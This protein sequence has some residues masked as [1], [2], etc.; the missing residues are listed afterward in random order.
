M[1]ERTL[2]I[3]YPAL[4]VASVT[5]SSHSFLP[6]LACS[7]IVFREREREREIA[8]W[9]S[10]EIEKE[11]SLLLERLSNICDPTANVLWK[12]SPYSYCIV[13]ILAGVDEEGSAFSRACK[14]AKWKRGWDWANTAASWKQTHEADHSPIS[15]HYC[16]CLY[17]SL[18]SICARTKINVVTPRRWIVSCLQ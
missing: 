18:I 17:C 1:V 6:C 14:E 7:Y 4:P 10:R 3:H 15:M 13:L 8:R 5:L 16:S 12:I 11:I 9:K 2:R